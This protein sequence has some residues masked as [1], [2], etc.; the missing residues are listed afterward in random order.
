M[1]Q[2]WNGY[3]Q[4]GAGTDVPRGLMADTLTAIVMAESWFEHRAVN[5]N[6]WGNRD[7]GVAQ[8]SDAARA[9]MIA[10]H[11]AGLVDVRL[12]DGDY[13]NPWQG[14]RFV[15]LWMRML[16]G[17]ASGDLD[18]AV[19]AYHRGTERALLG[20]GEDYLATVQR[21]RRLVRTTDASSPWAYLW[22]HGLPAAR[23]GAGSVSFV[24]RRGA[25]APQP[26]SRP[27][28]APGTYV[29]SGGTYVGSG[30]SRIARLTEAGGDVWRAIGGRPGPPRAAPMLTAAAGARAPAAPRRSRGPQSRGAPGC[31]GRARG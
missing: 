14:T 27:R 15:A 24:T 16:L 17:E 2:Y 26:P 10:L 25:P 29:G 23:L 4:V 8:A 19:R 1:T 20:E 31:A 22:A 6:P 3:Y 11:D 9:R 28:A 12:D 21:R 18:V 7:L 30:F 13:F 5:A